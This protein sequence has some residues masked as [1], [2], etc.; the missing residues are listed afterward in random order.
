VPTVLGEDGAK[1]SKRH[2]A[3]GVMEY[4]AAGFLPE[5]MVNFLAR[6]GWAHGDDEIFSRAQL[7]EWFS[8]E[9]IS[10]APSRFNADKLAWVNQ[11]HMKRMTASDLGLRLAPFLA[12][13][14]LDPANGPDAGEVAAL[15][16][17]RSPTLV[18]MAD[19]AAYFYATPHVDAAKFAEQVTPPVRDALLDL[20][21]GL[22]TLEW[23]REA[24][25]SA[26]KTAAARHGLKPP[27]V[28]MSMRLVV[29]G[30]TTTPAIDAVLHLLGREIVRARMGLT[31]A[32]HILRRIYGM[33]RVADLVYSVDPGAHDG[34]YFQ[35]FVRDIEALP[36]KLDVWRKR[37]S[38]FSQLDEAA[39]QNLK[40]RAVPRGR[41]R[42]E[43]RAW[44]GFI[45]CL[46]E[47][48][49]YI[50]LKSLGCND[51]QFVPESTTPAPDLVGSL[52]GQKVYCEVKTLQIS[53]TEIDRRE[54]NDVGST[55]PRLAPPFLNKVASTLERAKSQIGG[56]GQSKGVIL[57]V[58][59]FDDWI[60]DYKNDYY[61]QIDEFLG[62]TCN[63]PYELVFLDEGWPKEA[64]VS[65]R[66][67]RLLSHR[68][69]LSEA[70]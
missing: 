4:E 68:S 66:N 42:D 44:Q 30:T 7:V 9:G 13:A 10:P 57:M 43:R 46:N 47:A 1:L 52:H 22:A 25:A 33:E 20:H 35:G 45:A 64:T 59:N 21:A 3:T 65:M 51:I 40:G 48:R 27:Q 67:A 61:L 58:V 63:T 41:T 15:L 56:L 29:C 6:I 50:Y 38:E 12:R 26:M 49:G 18:Q 28:M 62:E 24:L 5:A 69:M 70:N 11:E 55:R 54:A 36:D 8:L 17:D 39:W 37:E 14:G 23:S 31:L 19:Q 60:G 32:P 2:G 53:D 16:R 34:A